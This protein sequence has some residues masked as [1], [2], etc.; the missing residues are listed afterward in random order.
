MAVV[1]GSSFRVQLPA[2]R[3]AHPVF[4]ASVLRPYVEDT[5]PERGPVALPP[6]AEGEYQ[7]ESVLAHRYYPVMP[8]SSRSPTFLVSWLGYS[9][10]EAT[11]E[12]LSNLLSE[13]VACQQLLDYLD[14]QDLPHP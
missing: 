2:G 6:N 11:W 10:D 4:H 8:T 14:A 9:I 13:G 1:S 3:R 12:P 5:W 7:V